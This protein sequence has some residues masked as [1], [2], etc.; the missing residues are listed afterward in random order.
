MKTFVI[1][2]IL[3]ISSCNFNNKNVQKKV[4]NSNNN[5]N[6][7]QIDSLKN[8]GYLFTKDIDF[9]T[10]KINDTISSINNNSSYYAFK[11]VNGKIYIYHIDNGEITLK[12][13]IE[14]FYSNFFKENRIIDSS[15]GGEIHYLTYY[16]SED[17]IIITIVTKSIFEENKIN[18][19]LSHLYIINNLNT[20][21]YT[22][23]LGYKFN[24][25]EDYFS[26]TKKDL[27]NIETVALSLFYDK[28]HVDVSKIPFNVFIKDLFVWDLNKIN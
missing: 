7:K 13:N 18:S 22:Y 9:F 23:N 17:K 15:D 5:M 1:L 19:Y 6:N 27:L 20:I 8:K 14:K 3:S 28:Q 21:V 10:L 4:F 11:K 2:L 24:L 12:R 16:Y 25:I 26:L